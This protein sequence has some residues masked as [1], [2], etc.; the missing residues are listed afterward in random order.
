MTET[1]LQ[2][3]LF[4]VLGGAMTGY[5]T[6][7]TMRTDLRNLRK[8]HGRRLGKLE[9]HRERLPKRYV[10]REEFKVVMN[11]VHRDLGEISSSVKAIRDIMMGRSLEPKDD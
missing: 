11:S 10:T 6:V 2:P 5:G 8:D 9:D 7:L 1:W 4:A 3:L